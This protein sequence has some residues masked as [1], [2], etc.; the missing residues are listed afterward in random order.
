[1][2]V[3][4]IIGLLFHAA[5]IP[6]NSFFAWLMSISWKYNIGKPIIAYIQ[7]CTQLLVNALPALL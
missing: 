1:M 4:G 3:T 5:P 7:S 6:A 2:I